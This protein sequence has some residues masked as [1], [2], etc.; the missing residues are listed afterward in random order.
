MEEMQTRAVSP[1]ATHPARLVS[2]DALRGFDMFI[3]LGV[4]ELAAA[5]A[6]AHDAPWTRFLHHHLDHAPW[7]GF[8]F[9]DLIFPLFLFVSGVSL[10]YSA[11]RSI[12]MR[13]VAATIGKFLIRGVILYALGLIYYGGLS[14]GWDEVRWVGVIQRIAVCGM[15][16]GVLY[17][18]TPAKARFG[19]F[20]GVLVG[21]LAGYWAVMT[22][23]PGSSGVLREFAEGPEHN[24]ANWIDLQYLPGKRWD[25]TH[26][27]EGLLSTI[28]ALGT[29]VLGAL[30]GMY[31]KKN[32]ASLGAKAFMLVLVGAVVAGLGWAWGLVP[33]GAGFPIIKKL[34]TSSYVLVAGG[35]SMMLL[36]VFV[37]TIDVRGWRWWAWPFVW[38]GM[39]AITLYMC[40]HL[41]DLDGVAAA[42]VGGPVSQAIT[43]YGPV[44]VAGMVLAL[45]T[46]LAWFM[47]SR[48]IFLRV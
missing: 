26:D 18:V 42:M 9:L 32:A 25:K 47:Y 15:V 24:Y 22:F 27:P 14:K 20:V 43:P 45:N 10:V 44:L 31:L 28:P 8:H 5:L 39:N 4:E 23:L 12:E 29:C 30:C 13:G 33:P 16:A 11:D 38:V 35:Y 2:L 17:C 21:V 19:V 48:K 46:L 1:H 40:R 37:W 7:E 3:I 41:L 34:W 36:G 6:K